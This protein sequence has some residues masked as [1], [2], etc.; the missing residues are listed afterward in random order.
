MLGDAMELAS[1]GKRSMARRRLP[2][3]GGGGS[4]AILFHWLGEE[5][6]YLK[7]VKMVGVYLQN[8][9]DFWWSHS[10]HSQ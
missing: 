10:I 6:I 1:V 2:P 5:M 9:H 3:I 8:D 7:N 4:C